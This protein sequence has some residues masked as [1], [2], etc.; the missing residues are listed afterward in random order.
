MSEDGSQDEQ[1][2]DAGEQETEG[3]GPMTDEQMAQLTADELEG[4]T[5]IG[6][7]G[8][9]IGDV[10]TLVLDDSGEIDKVIVDVGGFL[11]IGEKPVALPF[12]DLQIEQTGEGMGAIEVTTDHTQEELENM[13]S[14]DEV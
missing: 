11:G 8:D 10:S 5:V 7:E 6:S 13:E 12:D 1:M 4:Q 2:A 14:W 3:T 9:N